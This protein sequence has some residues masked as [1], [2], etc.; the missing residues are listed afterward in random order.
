MG[1]RGFTLFELIIT[2]AVIAIL[3][4]AGLPS[5]SSQLHSSRLKTSTQMLFE[6]VQLART[7]A[8]YSNKRVTIRNLGG[9]ENGW[10][11]FVDSNDDGKRN[12][13]ETLLQ[14]QDPL[15]DVKIF[16]NGPL[17]DYISFISNG[18]GRK[19]GRHNGGS[20]Q[21]GSMILCPK[22]AGSGLKLILSSGG[23]MRVTDASAE[24]CRDQPYPPT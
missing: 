12:D 11:I 8:V 6:S 20:L 5:L 7:K 1:N 19:A 14:T 2:L 9:W 16:A 17:R 3:T 22:T 4:A 21:M 23:R 10:E 24:Q 13:G 15:V 18:Q